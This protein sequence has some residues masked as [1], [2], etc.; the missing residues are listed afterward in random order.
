MPLECLPFGGQPLATPQGGNLGENLSGLTPTPASYLPVLPPF[1]AQQWEGGTGGGRASSW[2]KVWEGQGA[3][4]EAP[5]VY[6]VA[7]LS[8][9]LGFSN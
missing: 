1:S 5:C 8:S 2:E 4:P 3:L 6:T 7:F 9:F